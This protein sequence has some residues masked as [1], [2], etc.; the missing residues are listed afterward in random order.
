MSTEGRASNLADSD[1]ES[2]KV[3]YGAKDEKIGKIER[4]M[5]DKTSGNIL[6]AVLSFGGFLGI[7]AAPY[8]VPWN[9]LRYDPKLEGYRSDISAERL[10][11]APKHGTETV[12]EWERHSKGVDNYW[13]DPITGPE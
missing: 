4:V 1:K 12:F 3:V 13:G 7:G 10:R 9:V 2:G 8:P 6:Y 11:G 5:V